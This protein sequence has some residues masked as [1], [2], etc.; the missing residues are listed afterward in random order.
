[1]TDAKLEIQMLH[2]R[3][4]VRVSEESGERRSSG[5]IVIPATAQVAKRLLW[6][7]VYGVGSHVR[8]VQAGDQ[9]LFNPEEQYEVEVQGDIYLVLRERDLHAVASEQTEQGTGLYL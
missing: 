5:G 6:G 4:M 8:S 7:E 3:V 2:D 1:M 9:V